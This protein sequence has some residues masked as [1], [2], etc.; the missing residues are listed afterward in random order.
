MALPVTAIYAGIM[1]LWIIGLGFAVIRL[2]RRYDVSTGDGGVPE[3]ER[4][5]RAHGN[6]CEYAPIA[7]ILL[8]LAEGM[9]T[10]ARTVHVFGSMLV[11]GRLLH[12]GYFLAGAQR[13]PVR[14][15]AMVLTFGAIGALALGLI[16]Q[17]LARIG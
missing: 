2:R 5:V 16:F 4:A 8:G 15:F 9:G 12:G 1:G 13:L 3:L 14:V 7:L 11:I 17:A 10:P 6:A